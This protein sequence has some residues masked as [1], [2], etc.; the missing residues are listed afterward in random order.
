VAEVKKEQPL[1]IG[2][3]DV[4]ESNVGPLIANVVE[5]ALLVEL[6][7]LSRSSVIG[8][9][10]IRSMLDVEASKQSLGCSDESCLSE[11]ADAVG[12]DVLVVCSVAHTDSSIIAVRRIDQRQA[13][14]V[15]DVQKVLPRGNGGEFL[16]VIGPIV[17]EL[18]ADLPLRRGAVRGVTPE[19]ARALS[20]PPV[21]PWATWATAG[22]GVA[23]IAAGGVLVASATQ[24]HAGYVDYANR[25]KNEV[26]DGATLV[27]KGNAAN[28][29]LNAGVVVGAVGVGLGAVAGA[30]AV[31]T[32]WDGISS[33]AGDE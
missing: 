10:E 12:V 3:V 24:L 6:R 9:K 28:T 19:V 18:F 31:F 2:V 7:K 23:G 21:P 11:I 29:T 14:V 17:A 26:I 25:G 32:D 20:P 5:D 22:V 4:G 1:R 33:K 27:D 16:G 8:W 15:G 13:K 30:M